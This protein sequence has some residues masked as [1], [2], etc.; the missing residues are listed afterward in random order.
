M[1]TDRERKVRAG[2]IITHDIYYK[3][4]WIFRSDRSIIKLLIYY[5]E[6]KLMSVSLILEGG[7]TRGAYTAGV[8][9][10]FIDNRIFVNDVYGVSAGACNSLSYVSRQRGRNFKIFD[11]YINDSRYL[12]MR[13]YIKTGSFFGLDFIFGELSRELVPFDYYEFFKSHTR[14]TVGATDCVTGKPVYFTKADMDKDFIAVKASSS[15]PIV[16]PIVNFKGMK[17]LDGGIGDPILI[18][19]AIADGHEFNIIVLTQDK[20][21]KKPPKPDFPEYIL[22]KKFKDYPSFVETML[23]R[24]AVYNRQKELC[25][26]LQEQGKAIVIQ[27][28]E[29]MP[30]GRYTKDRSKLKK[31]YEWG[32]KDG[33]NAA[34]EIR[35]FMIIHSKA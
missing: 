4:I 17:L 5:R 29:P 27:P 28:P 7:G 22:R 12:S 9:D 33:N 6:V 24:P 10:A 15:L 1:L 14:L 31:V 16:S 32:L 3:K 21:Y 20:Y 34:R 26:M 2:F 8:L 18:E 35:R 25:Y 30:V 19:K 13:S 23:V 11:E